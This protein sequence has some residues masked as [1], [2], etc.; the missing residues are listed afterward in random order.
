M[1][2]LQ[3]VTHCK[4]IMHPLIIF[5]LTLELFHGKIPLQWCLTSFNIQF[6]LTLFRR[7]IGIHLKKVNLQKIIYSIFH[8][9][10]W[11]EE[12]DSKNKS[13]Y[14]Y[15]SQNFERLKFHEPKLSI[16]VNNNSVILWTIIWKLYKNVFHW[17]FLN[18]PLRFTVI[19]SSELSFWLWFWHWH[20]LWLTETA[21]ID[22]QGHTDGQ[23]NDEIDIT[24]QLDFWIF[25]FLDLRFSGFMSFCTALPLTSIP[26]LC[27]LDF[28]SESTAEKW[29]RYHCNCCCFAGKMMIFQHKSSQYSLCFH[30]SWKNLLAI[31]LHCQWSCDLVQ[32]FL[33]TLIHYAS[34][35]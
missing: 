7:M 9:S 20:W 11:E 16:S 30:F 14:S 2:S 34:S 5:L 1:N 31:W 25:G 27:I 17:S 10:P 3:E 13:V 12:N 15:S 29:K 18:I 32:L 6:Q 21:G 8:I 24:C 22:E 4:S 35:K 23:Y 26:W 28:A 33:L 19:Q